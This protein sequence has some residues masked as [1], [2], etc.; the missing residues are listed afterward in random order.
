MKKFIFVILSVFLLFTSCPGPV[1]PIDP[2]EPSEPIVV[3]PSYLVNTTI[4]V[5]EQALYLLHYISNY[6][7]YIDNGYDPYIPNHPLINSLKEK[8]LAGG[9]LTSEEE[10]Q[11]RQLVR[12][13]LYDESNYIQTYNIINDLI[14][15]LNEEVLSLIQYNEKWGFKMFE[16]YNIYLTLYNPGGQYNPGNG[17]IIMLAFP[18][19]NIDSE[20]ILQVVLHETVHI[21]IEE[22]IIQ[23]Y[24]VPQWTKERIVEQFEYLHF[25]Y[26]PNQWNSLEVDRSIDAIFEEPDVLDHLPERVGEFMSN[27]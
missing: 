3:Q 11:I 26:I 25:N 1:S 16:K 7:W 18:N 2:I 4:P 23:K 13:E 22:N 17:N 8:V 14:P 27:Q 9:T 12:D 21:G 10:E 20:E 15:I 5:E 6:K 24:Q 19:D